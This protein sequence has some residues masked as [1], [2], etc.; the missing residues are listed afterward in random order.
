MLQ[1]R[2]WSSVAIVVCLLIWPLARRAADAGAA[3]TRS[4]R[5]LAL[6]TVKAVQAAQRTYWTVH[7]Y[8]DRL[9][10][11]VQDACVPN[12]Y[13]PTY[14]AASASRPHAYGYEFRLSDGPRVGALTTD[15]VSGT[16]M[17]AF[18][19]TAVPDASTRTAAGAPSFCA[20]AEGLYEYADARTPA[21][22]DGRCVERMS[23]VP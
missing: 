16:G 17:T 3:P 20:D 8:Y 13:P 11:L 7:G 9:E 12:P 21:V 4:P 14:L 15:F 23:S 10:C 5:E 19:F 18:A 6:D 22:R 2:I 1:R